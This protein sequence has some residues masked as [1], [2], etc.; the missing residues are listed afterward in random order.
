MAYYQILYWQE[1]PSQVKAWDDFD[2]VKFE[3]SEKFMQEID[4][5]AQRKGLTGTD[6]YLDQWH[7]SDEQERDG[8]PQA[9][10]E[11]LRTELEATLGD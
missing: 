4:R 10:A 6:D 11:A 9:V 5:T 3:L 8:D 7:W 2:E 1:I